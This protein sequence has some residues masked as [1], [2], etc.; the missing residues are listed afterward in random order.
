[1]S[2]ALPT[3]LS[4]LATRFQVIIIDTPPLGAGIDPFALG[5]AT[6]NMLLVLRSGET[7]R[8][9]AEAKL[10]LLDRLPVRVLGAVLNDISAKGVYRYYS[11]LSEYGSTEEIESEIGATARGE[12]VQPA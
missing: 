4:R 6:G 9:M 12:L 1:M 8:K 5:S 11:Y 7:D 10:Q 2:P 3:L